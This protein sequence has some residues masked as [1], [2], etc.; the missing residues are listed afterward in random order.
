MATMSWNRS[1]HDEDFMYVHE[2]DTAQDSFD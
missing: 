2:E 1:G